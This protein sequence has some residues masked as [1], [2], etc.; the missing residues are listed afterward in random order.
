VQA[1]CEKIRLLTLMRSLLQ[2]H[3]RRVA[4]ALLLM[5][6]TM[7]G[8]MTS[9]LCV[10]SEPKLK[11]MSLAELETSLVDLSPKVLACQLEGTVRAVA[12]NLCVLALQD[13]SGTALLEL[14]AMSSEVTNGQHVVI[15]ANPGIMSR[16]AF[17]VRIENVPTIDHNGLHSMTEKSCKLVLG[18]EM[19]PIRL[20]WFNVPAEFA[21]S[22]EYEGPD[23]PRQKVPNDVLWRSLRDATN[24]IKIV[25][26]LQ[27]SAYQ[28]DAYNAVSWQ[29]LPN[30]L[31]LAP[32]ATGVATNF[33]VVYRTSDQNCGLSFD[34]FIKIDRAG[35]YIFYLTSDDGSRLYVGQPSV[36][37]KSIA[38]G[39]PTTSSAGASD[40]TSNGHVHDRWVHMEGEVTFVAENQVGLD[41]EINVSGRRI[42]VRVMDRGDLSPAKLLHRTIRIEGV[43]KSMT[44][45]GQALVFVPVATQVSETPTGVGDGRVEELLTTAMQVQRLSPANAAK[46]LPAKIRGVVIYV[47]GS[48]VVLSDF[49]GGVFITS[50]L[51]RWD[52]QPDI[53]EFWEMAGTT[54]AGDFSPVVSADKATFLGFAPMP[55]PVRPV[56]DQLMNGNLD[57]QYGELRGVVASV[58]SN[59]IVLLLPEGRVSVV[60]S[61]DRPLPEF[62]DAIV[63]EGRLIGSVVRI[64]GCFATLVDIQSRRVIPGKILIY[65][66]KVEVEEPRPVD[67]FLLT[68]KT[69]D[70]LKWFDARGTVLQRTKLAGQIVFVTA[71]EL[72]IE[73]GG[74]GFRVY[75]NK[76]PLVK[77]GDLVETVGF[78]KLGGAS[79]VL[80][81]AQIRVTGNAHLS[82][83][84]PIADDKL[85]D[86]TLDS[87]LV[88]VNANLI[89]DT[90][91]R[92]ERVLALQNGPHHLVARLKADSHETHL[93]LPGSELQL[94]GVYVWADEARGRFGANDTPFELLLSNPTNIVVLRKPSW[95]TIRRAIIVASALAGLLCISFV[96]VIML[97]RKV[98]QRTTQLKK[99]IEERQLAEQRRAIEQERIR[100]ARDLHDELGAG[101]TEVGM[102]GSLA[103]TATVASEVR[104]RYLGQLT[105][106]ARSLV[107]A[108]DEIVWAVNPDYDTV[109]S[110]VSYFSLY[111][112][113]FLSLAGIKCRLQVKDSIPEQALD[114]RFRHGLLCAFKEALNNVVRHANATEVQTVFESAGDSLVISIADNGL[115]FAKVPESS[116]KDGLRGLK[117][118][119]QS[120][121]GECQIIS[122]PGHG[123]R[124]VMRLPLTQN[125]HGK[126]C[127]R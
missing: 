57:A 80:V 96:W 9:C 79:P 69:V 1:N 74:V 115:G 27:Y 71:R 100:M 5:L 78:P 32:T 127:D 22:L 28:K 36:T 84:V 119:L 102:L 31:Q 105:N 19:N 107:A 110:L 83:P 86:R 43:S 12:P 109:P 47:R 54:D 16:T 64:R 39:E 11:T 30:F 26:G 92:D 63:S 49:S 59:E 46:H 62:P 120:L 66:A 50:R 24:Q 113:S 112:E 38:S 81:E 33:S 101:L 106:V 53:G 55:E 23:L 34:G 44:P 65:P 73:Q 45:S 8:L 35:D 41:I 67:P 29:A 94:T 95:W 6:I 85:M 13:A 14:P 3:Q 121:G 77:I 51:L 4:K 37:C 42:P 89:R 56:W 118:R 114:S 125:Q 2:F 116:G 99:E 7:S 97:R 75:A 70:D 88:T 117:E 61:D 18:R 123:T 10:A 48:S 108:L 21:L 124:I 20:I 111:A 82:K 93:I 25:P 58:S 126:N 15:E 87:T 90:L 60:S 76:L 103:N 104:D 91:D 52:Q 40:Q 17:G 68:T 98:Q 72:F 122:E